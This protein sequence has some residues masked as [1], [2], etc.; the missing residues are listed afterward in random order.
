MFTSKVY[1]IMVGSLSGAMEEVY[2]AKETIHDWNQ[3]N[4]RRSG[5][6]FMPIEWNLDPEHIQSVDVVIGVIDNWVDNPEVIEN[7]IEA[8]KRVLLFFNADQDPMNTIRSEFEEVQ[9]FMKR[10]QCQCYCTFYN[11]IPELGSLLNKQ[12]DKF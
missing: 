10:V 2:V 6:L 12:L 7:C 1:T 9:S 11:G 4:A 5:Y 8:G 3:L